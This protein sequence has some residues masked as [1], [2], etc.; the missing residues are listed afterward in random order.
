MIAAAAASSS[1]LASSSSTS[2]N[3]AT[4]TTSNSISNGSSGE[5]LEYFHSQLK[6]IKQN[7]LNVNNV[8]HNDF[9]AYFVKKLIPHVK[10][11]AY[12]WFHLQAAKRKHFKNEDKRMNYADEQQLKQRLMVLKSIKISY[13]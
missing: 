13:L 1:S 10:S 11:F 7:S 4:T 12:T 2:A 8:Y 3:S 9:G 6:S 5:P